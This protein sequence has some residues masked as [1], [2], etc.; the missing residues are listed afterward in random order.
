M[1]PWIFLGW[2][3]AVAVSLIVV[4]IAIAVVIALVKHLTGKPLE[5]RRIK[6]SV[7]AH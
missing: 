7:N 4:T 3:V 5:T 2:A 6:K 1:S